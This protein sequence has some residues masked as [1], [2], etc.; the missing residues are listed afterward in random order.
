MQ[1]GSGG[2]PEPRAMH[3]RLDS[4]PGVL[5]T[6]NLPAGM[7][8]YLNGIGRTKAALFTQI[9]KRPSLGSWRC[10]HSHQAAPLSLTVALSETSKP[11][12]RN[13]NVLSN[14]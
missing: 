11:I 7:T 8:A 6:G 12:F 4:P 3:G 10:Y 14:H 1:L 13:S 9:G 2:M 5:D